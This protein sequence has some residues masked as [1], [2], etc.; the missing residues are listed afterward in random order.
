MYIKD[1]VHCEQKISCRKMLLLRLSLLF[2][3]IASISVSH[4]YVYDR[5]GFARELNDLGV[6]QGRT[7][8]TYVCI[9]FAE[10]SFN[11]DAIG[12]LNDDDSTDYGIF[13]INN[14][15]WCSDGKYKS[16]NGCGVRCK[17]LLGESGVAL[18]LKCAEI[19]RAESGW[20]AWTTY[21]KCHNPQSNKD[22]FQHTGNQGLWGSCNKW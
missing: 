9:A 8:D 16:S 10:S 22:C 21:Y 7:L 14:R 13:Q 5:C 20:K 17:D 11:T 12:R 15:Y 18:S 6:S 3:F 1:F 2:A 4:G 19:V